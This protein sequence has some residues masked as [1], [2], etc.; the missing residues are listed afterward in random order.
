MPACKL[1]IAS[2]S[3]RDKAPASRMIRFTASQSPV[4]VPSNICIC[5]ATA[6][7]T[8]RYGATSMPP[9]AARVCKPKS[10]WCCSRCLY[11]I[12]PML[13]LHALSA[14]MLA[15]KYIGWLFN[16][17]QMTLFVTVITAIAATLLGLL[18][19]AARSSSLR[20]L[21][22]PAK[23]Y[24]ALFRNTPLLVQL[25]FWYFGFPSLFPEG[26]MEWLNTVHRLHLFGF[27]P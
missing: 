5:M 13:D 2:A 6:C 16:G 24:I 8:C 3:A 19:A 25:L 15:P 23:A 4:N 9:T 20:L 7:W 27:I 11:R 18:L 12:P 21:A 10:R 22:W 1:P 14:Q 26:T 17:L